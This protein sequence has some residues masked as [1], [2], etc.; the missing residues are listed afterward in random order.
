VSVAPFPHHYVVDLVGMDL[1]SAG[2][3]PIVIGAPPQ[4]GGADRAWSPEDL[5]LGAVLSCLR[6]TFD[7]YARRI[8]LV[9]SSWRGRAT[10]TL[11]KGRA[12]PVFSSIR[13]E[14]DLEVEPGEEAR[15]EEVIRRAERDCIISRALSAPVALELQI[16][17]RS[18]SVSP[19]RS[20]EGRT[21]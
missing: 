11:D 8:G 16:T 4:F 19:S 3:P 5:L 1:S 21:A 12:G 6:T 2:L 13:L 9:A 18:S 20:M 10:G 7:A 17:T 15:A 14:V